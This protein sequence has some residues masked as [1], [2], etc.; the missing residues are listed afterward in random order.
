[1]K[2]EVHFPRFSSRRP[3]FFVAVFFIVGILLGDAVWHGR[4][5]VWLAAVVAGALAAGLCVVASERV[6]AVVAALL[7]VWLGVVVVNSYRAR[8][9]WGDSFSMLAG[10]GEECL[11]EGVVLDEPEARTTEGLFGAPA[12]CLYRFHLRVTGVSVEDDTAGTVRPAGGRVVVTATRAGELGIGYGDRV[13]FRGRVG[14]PDPARNPGGFDY[15]EY[16]ERKGIQ[17]V[18]RVGAREEIERLGTGG[19]LA[20]RI[21]YSVRGRLE[22]ALEYGPM[23]DDSRAFLKGVLLGKRR[24]ISEEL[25]EA[26]V[27]TN[28]VHVLAISGLH[29]AIVALAVHWVFR[30]VFL[31]R[32]AA[33]V[34]T[35]AVIALYAAMTGGRASVVRASVMMGVILMA[36][37]VRRQAD[38]LSSL[39]LAA[40]LILLFRPL[41]VFSPGFQLSFVAAGGVVILAPRLIEW[42]A[43]RWHLR[44][45][46]GVDVPGWRAG[47]NWLALRLVQ[48]AAVCVA[49]YVA[50]AP[51]TAFHFNRFAPLSF[52]P[53]VAVVALMGFIVPLG[54]V[55]A[56][57]GQV[58]PFAAGVLNAVNGVLIGALSQV[59][60]LT[61]NLR[62]IHLNV[63]SAPV[64]VLGA[65]YGVLVAVGFAHGASR[66]LRVALVA[67]LAV[68]GGVV[69]WSPVMGTPDC[70]EV[71]VLDVGK[72]ESIFVRT[73]EGR[74]ILIDGGMVLGSDPG[75]WTIMPFLRSRGYNRLDAV[76]LT[77][78]DSDH[79]GGLTHVVEHIGVRRFIVRGGPESRKAHRV[80]GLLGLVERRGIPIERIEAGDR[81]TPVGDTPIVALWPDAD[82]HW[83]T[84]ENNASIVLRVDESGGMLLTSDVEHETERRLLDS[85]AGRLA[86]GVLKVPHQGSKQSS[87]PEFLDAVEPR[88]AIITADRFRIH[89]HPAPEIVER[90][91][92]RGIVVLRT[93]EHGAITVRLTRDGVRV[94][95]MLRGADEP[96]AVLE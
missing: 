77:H 52:I 53:N 30:A 70:A 60:V 76:V 56:V 20:W 31:P 5:A 29:V 85:E 82:L 6:G 66:T 89:P 93:D 39:A 34:L 19:S 2:A 50:V 90:Y 61:S 14:V 86:A 9:S 64:L 23:S 17:R 95:T 47:I 15:R 35:L 49:A 13:R 78:Y 63:R 69:M 58:W 65:Y 44:P 54:M 57:V 27:Y 16:L 55:A 22:R 73:R 38:A 80:A 8:V 10:D 62:L 74:R 7:A 28:T 88:L 24:A 36:P 41:D 92:E 4:L 37:V 12:S 42:A 67:A 1:V 40:V 59:V 81:L 83:A 75:R 48:L 32:W 45:E 87:T 25:E 43:E 71:V 91:K 26:L 18:V 21:V 96:G 84:S 51:L 79:Y 3:I 46:P 11:I 94:W 72:G 33:S 68:V